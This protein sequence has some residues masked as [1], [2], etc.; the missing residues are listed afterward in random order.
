MILM[1]SRRSL[2]QRSRSAGDCH[3]NLVNS[4]APESLKEFEQKL[5]LKYSMRTDYV[6]KVIDSKVKVTEN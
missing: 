5:T 6:F 2:G 1:T 3:V 4:I